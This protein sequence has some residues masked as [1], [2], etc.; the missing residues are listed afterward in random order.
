MNQKC[1]KCGAETD[2]DGDLHCRNIFVEEINKL[3]SLEKLEEAKMLYL[4]ASFDGAWKESFLC[5][6]SEKF[7]RL[8]EEER[9]KAS[10]SLKVRLTHCYYCKEPLNNFSDDKCEKCGWIKCSCG[11]CGCRYDKQKLAGN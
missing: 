5:V 8:I 9:E 4:S 11:A 2:Y 3:L 7:K 6:K 1:S 10:S